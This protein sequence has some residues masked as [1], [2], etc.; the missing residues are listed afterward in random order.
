MMTVHRL[1][2]PGGG[3]GAYCG[4]PG[5]ECWRMD[6]RHSWERLGKRIDDL[7]LRTLLDLSRAM[8]HD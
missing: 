3:F 7:A 2:M 4:D 6:W 8:R 1:P 5:L